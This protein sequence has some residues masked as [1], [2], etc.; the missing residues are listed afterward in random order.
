[1]KIYTMNEGSFEVPEEWKDNSLNIFVVGGSEPPM[2]LSFVISRDTLRDGVELVDYVE[3][4]LG[5]VGKKLRKF[6]V[7]GKRQIEVNGHPALEA[8]FTWISDKSPMHQRQ[9]YIRRGTTVL[10]FTAT[11]PVKIEDEHIEQIDALLRSVRFN[12]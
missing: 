6:R 3:K 11:A 4:Q 1:M 12:V 5:D 10:V 2:N 7:I 8:E 9:Q